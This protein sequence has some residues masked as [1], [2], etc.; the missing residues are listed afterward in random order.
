MNDDR[1]PPKYI[2]NDLSRVDLYHQYNMH[3]KSE[4]EQ[5][6]IL[7][8]TSHKMNKSVWDSDPMYL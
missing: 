2:T 7:M 1:F 3:A 6:I 8:Q 4:F 5:L